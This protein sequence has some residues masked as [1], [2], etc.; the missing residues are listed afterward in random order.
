MNAIFLVL[1]KSFRQ[2]KGKFIL[3]VI[4][5]VLSSWG[6]SMVTYSYLMSERDFKEN[7]E[8]TN[9]PSLILIVD[10]DKEKAAQEIRSHSEVAEIESRETFSGRVKNKSG[11]WTSFV[12][13]VAEDL[14]QTRINTF[15]TEAAPD[16]IMHDVRLGNLFIERNALG[17]VNVH[18]T[19]Q[20]QIPGVGMFS[21]RYSGK[22]FDPSLPPA[23]MEQTVYAFTD[24]GTV[25]TMLNDTR[26]RFLVRV[27]DRDADLVKLQKIGNEIETSLGGS[28]FSVKLFIPPPGEHLHQNIVNGISFLQKSF[29]ISLSLLGVILLSL[30]LVTWLYPQ[31]V[32]IGISKS[33]G[34]S[35]KRI[36]YAYLAVIGL[37]MVFGI[38]IGL[39]LGY[40]TAALYNKA[41]AYLQNFTPVTRALPI[42]AHIIVIAVILVVPLLVVLGPLTKTVSR[43]VHDALS[44]IF[45]T[46]HKG[47]FKWSQGLFSSSTYRYSFNNLFRNN[48]RTWLLVVLLTIGIGLLVTGFNLKHSLRTEFNGFT[49]NSE[50]NISVILKD[51]LSKDYLSFVDSLPA[52]E[53]AAFLRRD[54]ITFKSARKSYA[55]NSLVITFSNDYQLNPLLVMSGSIKPDCYDCIYL[56]Q[57]MLSEFEGI[58]EGEIIQLKFTDGTTKDYRFSGIIKELVGPASFYRFTSNPGGYFTDIAVKYNDEIGL[59]KSTQQIDDA[60][61]DHNV[62]VRQIVAAETVLT[63]LDNHLQPTYLII[64]MMGYVTIAIAFAGMVIVLNLSLQER[65]R[66]I[67]IT[68]SLGGSFRDIALAFQREFFVITSVSI[69]AGVVGG[70]LLSSAICKL[71]GVMLIELEIPPL[72]DITSVG[73]SMLLFISVQIAFIQLYIRWK[74]GKASSRLL[75]EVY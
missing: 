28:G 41:I 57:K 45:Y 63:M 29:G 4:A 75:V 7:F 10:G 16:S 52:I 49:R 42:S 5:G 44:Q 3:C 70:H 61:L 40:K 47:M 56:G 37:I 58:V 68:K 69:V 38:A 39:P 60:M 11:G 55:D 26:T 33:I 14:Q 8:S 17:F 59:A 73:L 50:Y 12:L 46:P 67:G 1:L 15:T 9:P 6:I 2:A 34:A 51:S 25:S 43:S 53:T 22:A 35:T 23:Q 18:D 13:F 65:A 19:L 64:Q 24:R 20:V 30:I 66:E 74:V 48:Q 32:T 62:E 71:F 54:R 21:F 36:I 31:M 72:I 27:R